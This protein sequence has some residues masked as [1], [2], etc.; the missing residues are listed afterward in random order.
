[1]SPLAAQTVT[2]GQVVGKLLTT[3][4]GEE[5]FLLRATLPVPPGT[6]L[7]TEGEVPLTVASRHLE[8]FDTQIEVVSR[9][10]NPAD[11]AD[12]VE[13]IAQVD[14][15]AGVDEGDAIVYWV[16]HTPQPRAAFAHGTAVQELLDTPGALTLTTADVFGHTYSTDLYER[17][18]NGNPTARL[19]KDGK[20]VREWSTHEVLMP[21]AP[22]SGSEGTLPHMMGVHAYF[23]TYRAEDFLTLDLHVHNGMDGLDP[24]DPADDALLNLYFASLELHLPHGWRV[25][26]GFDS[27]FAGETERL[28]NSNWTPLV[29]KPGQNKL[30]VMGR[31][32]RFVRRLAIV[33]AGSE[34]AQR[35][36]EQMLTSRTRAFSRSGPSPSGR[37]LWSWWN[38]STA[39]YF[40]Q[41]H[42]LPKLDH[43]GLYPIDAEL[44][45]E[46]QEVEEL[47][48]T[49]SQESYPLTSP[50]LGWA[51][52]WGS[53]YGGM[54]GGDEINPYD[55][56]ATAAAASTSG[57][58]LAQL[59]SRCYLD[60][61]PT[62]LYAMNGEPCRLE[63]VVIPEG[64]YGP[65]MPMF[66]K[67]R[68]N[69]EW[70]EPFGFGDAPTFQ[71]VAVR[72]ANRNPPYESDLLAF[73][74]I[75]LAHYVRFTRNLKILAWLGN[76]TLAK[77]QIEAA[78]EL[79]RMSFHQYRNSNYNHIQVSGL[80]QK[81]L[82][83]DTVPNNGV[84]IGRGQ[85]W[86]ID[87]SAAAYATGS[88]RYRSLTLPWFEMIQEVVDRGVSGCRGHV[89]AQ[90]AYNYDD[91]Q[92]RV[93]QS[94]ESAILVHGLRGMS[95]S[96]FR[97]VQDARAN[98]IDDAIASAVL[99][100]VRP[101]FWDE[102]H[103]APWF[104]VAVSPA[105]ALEREFC[106]RYPA[107]S[108]NYDR[109]SYFSALAYGYELSGNDLFLF[110]AAQLLGGGDLL[111][112]L[113][114]EGLDN[115]AN[116]AALLALCQALA[117][118]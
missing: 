76:D 69:L 111:T 28:D 99:A 103:T 27:P 6:Y 67:L 22:V 19:R 75:D 25:L 2:P 20:L 13:L 8:A 15:P 89:M 90:L 59:V 48:R 43:V 81:Q 31:Q 17:V 34:S 105:S 101:P 57:Y 29:G 12:V 46:L 38:S 95:E 68:P 23:T 3:A 7:G 10:A 64:T 32:A 53:P 55:G 80:L 112:A 37:G 33:R 44:R 42:V 84:G 78:A 45:R 83:T 118:H 39:R 16:G 72:Q 65:W 93:R 85:G 56:L 66:F 51:H 11:G 5:R 94:I 35:R 30:H 60:R 96:L 98:S 110:K 70:D 9:Y 21:D 4:P 109:T 115:L 40:P 18:R 107:P 116:T 26:H 100:A 92:F 50:G 108:D 36:A 52:P 88:D 86:G 63:D 102:G 74:P 1:M 24:N 117:G 82:D 54:T 79:F 41:N 97:G 71:T 61:Q 104:F 87:T 113:E 106:E 58:R 73:H 47:V 91:G 62:A 49:G 77:D 114:G 14:S